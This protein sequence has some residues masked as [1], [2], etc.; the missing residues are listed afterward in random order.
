MKRKAQFELRKLIP[1]VGL[2]VLLSGAILFSHC[3]KEDEVTPLTGTDVTGEYIINTSDG[4]TL[5]KSHSAINWQTA[6]IGDQAF[7]TGKFNK[8]GVNV[9]FDQ[10]NLAASSISS[11]VVLSTANTGEPGRDGIGKCLNGYLGVQHNGDTLENG[12][13]DP[14]GII[15]SS[16]TARF[17]TTDI[18]AYGSGYKAIGNL[19]FKGVTKPAT[20][21]FT[22]TTEKDYSEDQDGSKLRASFMGDLN[23]NAKSDYGVTSTSIADLINVR[24]N[25]I[26]RKNP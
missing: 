24:I 26:F 12:S 18:V 23:F 17:S 6:Y 13:I 14:N 3:T 21:V 16:D 19:E 25:T 9:D 22:Y 11:W 5:D 10:A 2:L 7:L 1:K 15:G 8:F 4:W 20:L